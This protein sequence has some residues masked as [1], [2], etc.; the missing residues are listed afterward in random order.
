MAA[1]KS[2]VGSSGGDDWAGSD[3]T[4]SSE[5]YEHSVGSLALEV[6]GQNWSG[7]L[8]SGVALSCHMAMDLLCQEMRDACW[9]SSEPLGSPLSLC[10]QCR[11]GSLAEEWEGQPQKPFSQWTG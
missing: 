9:V 11:E 10:W 6:I 3:S 5:E 2:H 4:S 7:E 8:V 1:Q